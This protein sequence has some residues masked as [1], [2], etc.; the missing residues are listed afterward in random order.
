MCKK[1][2]ITII[3]STYLPNLGALWHKFAPGLHM[4]SLCLRCVCMDRAARATAGCP[5]VLIKIFH[6][7]FVQRLSQLCLKTWWK[8]LFFHSRVM[9]DENSLHWHQIYWNPWKLRPAASNK[10]PE[11][12]ST[13]L[14]FWGRRTN[15]EVKQS[16]GQCW[17]VSIVNFCCNFCSE[18]YK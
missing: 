13:L 5:Q 6:W 8:L 12:R 9:G 4:F 2:H 11:L 18:Q 14:N 3:F 15:I 10:L 17:T 7:N 1:I 16:C